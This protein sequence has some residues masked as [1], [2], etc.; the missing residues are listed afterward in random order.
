MLLVHF[1][2]MAQM[3]VYSEIAITDILRMRQLTNPDSGDHRSFLLRSSSLYFQQPAQGHTF[4]SKKF[5]Y[6]I[7]NIG[8]TWQ[9]ND[10]LGLGSNDGSFIPAAGMQQRAHINVAARWGKFYL[11]LA[12]EF[13]KAENKPQQPYDLDP[14]FANLL[15]SYYNLVNGHIDMYDRIGTQPLNKALPGQSSLKFQSSH[16]AVGMSTENIWWGP[17]LRNSL[18]LSNH[19]PSF[20]H[21]TLQTVKPLKTSFGHIEA[22]L[23]T[24]RLKEVEFVNPDDQKMRQ[25][26]S[27]Y[28]IRAKDTFPRSFAGYI[29]TWEP[30]WTK[31]LFLGVA[32]SAI[33]YRN[34]AESRLLVFPFAKIERQNRQRLG[35]FFMRYVMPKEQAEIYLEMGRSDRA[36]YPTNIIRD[37]I[38]MGYTAGFRKLKTLGKNYG[39]LHFGLELTRLQLPDPRLLLRPNNPSGLPLYNSWYIHENIRQGYTNDAQVMGAWIGPGSNSQTLQLGWVKGYKKLMITGE[40]V[41][42]N[43]DFY[44]YFFY[45]DDLDPNR[46]NTGK[47][48]ADV[49]ATVQLQWDYKNILFSAGTSSTW[50]FNY[51]WTKLDGGFSGASKLSDRRNRQLY[52]SIVWFFDGKTFK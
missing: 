45:K 49:S 34:N 11:Q 25:F 15:P 46:Q 3:E 2:G 8:V 48:W 41:Q 33:S 29:A 13:I 12:P 52:A 36:A 35:S 14:V 23:I 22:Q 24:G 21:F 40:R 28:W 7:R 27:W 20:L 16:I 6:E 44:Y 17:A 19:A 50:L 37:S 18:V 43:N 38:P 47:Y 4:F 30:K 51:K 31:N 9:R 32:G 39:Y 26:F 42:H 5:S 10:S 1:T